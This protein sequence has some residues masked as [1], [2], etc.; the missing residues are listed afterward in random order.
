MG[1]RGR[2]AV[3][4]PVRGE[5]VKVAGATEVGRCVAEDKGGTVHGFGFLFLFVMWSGCCDGCVLFGF[6]WVFFC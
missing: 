1:F 2:N 5:D 3:V 6:L 4:V